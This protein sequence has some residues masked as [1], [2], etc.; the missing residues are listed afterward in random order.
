MNQEK[1]YLDNIKNFDRKQ[2]AQIQTYYISKIAYNVQSI[3]R[4]IIFLYI[5]LAAVGIGISLILF[6]D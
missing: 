1:K 6:Y 3:N 4:S 2:F 5:A